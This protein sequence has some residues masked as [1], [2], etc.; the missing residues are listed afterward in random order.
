MAL[1]GVTSCRDLDTIFIQPEPLGFVEINAV[2]L[3]VA[4]SRIQQN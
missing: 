2:L 3:L 4:L 1:F